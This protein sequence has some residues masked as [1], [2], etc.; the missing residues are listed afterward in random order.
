MD[1]IRF[2]RNTY[3]LVEK[4][5]ENVGR[6]AEEMERSNDLTESA[7]NVVEVNVEGHEEEELLAAVLSVK[8]PITINHAAGVIQANPSYTRH[9]IETFEEVN[10]VED[11][12]V[13]A[14]E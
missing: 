7:G 10:V 13:L 6:L 3:N 9:A 11:E 2:N 4:L 1:E 12:V 5:T 8:E 14:E